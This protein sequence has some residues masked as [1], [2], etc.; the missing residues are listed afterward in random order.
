MTSSKKKKTALIIG[1]GP[2]GLTAAYQFLKETDIVPV[3]IEQS[4]YWGGISRT[5]NYKGNRIDIG[6]HRFF[7]KSTEV[8][9]WWNKIMPVYSETNSIRLTYQNQST[10]ISIDNEKSVDPDDQN[11]FLVR[12]RKSRIIYNKNLFDYPV[13][14]SYDTLSKLGL[15]N[16]VLIAFS[17]FRVLLFPIRDEK[18]LEDFFINRFGRRLYR[19]F[20]KDYTEKVWGVK[21]NEISAE[22]GRQRIKGLTVSKSVIHFLRKKFSIFATRNL[23]QKNTETS[24]IEYFLYPKYGPGQLWDLV[25]RKIEEKGGVLRQRTLLEQIE[26]VENSVKAVYVRDLSNNSIERM[27]PDYVISSMPVVDLVNSLKGNLVIPEVKEIANGLVYRDFITVGILCKKLNL[28]SLDDNWIYVQEPAVRVGRI[29][30]FNN[31]SPYLVADPAMTWVGL[32][33]FCYEKDDLWMLT[34]P[35]LIKL[36]IDELGVL[37]MLDREN[38]VDG[39][40]IKM[41]KAYPAY[42]GA[43]E[44]FSVLRTYLDKFENLFLIGRNGMHK[45][46]N[47]DHSMLTA[48]EAVKVIRDNVLDKHR[49]WDINTEQDYHESR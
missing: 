14:L 47:Q 46:N 8:M 21:C 36:A 34:E 29:Q 6:G 44:S 22:W 25:A 49:I 10:F 11:V 40:V 5:V 33:F 27:E 3:V 31:W 19:T 45:Y 15:F 20:F 2:A 42:F 17:Y 48:I 24:L 4:E 1:G 16:S 38:Y 23:H 30:I 37:G 9:E 12:K 26:V 32:E 43:Y 35:E 18:S 39:V 28:D 13:S 41:P 7:S